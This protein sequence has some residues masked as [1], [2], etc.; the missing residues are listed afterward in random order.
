MRIWNQLLL[1]AAVLLG[2]LCFWVYLSAVACRTMV[3]LG[4]PEAIVSS[5]NPV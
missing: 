4:V 5:I 2:G 3:T 1:S